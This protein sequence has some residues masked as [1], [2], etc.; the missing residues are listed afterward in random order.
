M[1]AANFDQAAVSKTM[2]YFLRHNPAAGGLALDQ[3][4]WTDFLELVGALNAKFGVAAEDVLEI[5][6]NDAKRRYVVSGGRIRAS[7]GHSVV[8]DL[9]LNAKSPPPR[10]YHGTVQR[11]LDSIFTSGLLKQARSHVHLSEDI[12]TAV[13][14]AIR[15]KHDIPAILEVDSDSMARQGHTFFLSENG[16][17]LVGSVPPEFLLLLEEEAWKGK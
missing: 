16:V 14:V 12:P 6:A 4:G 5:V 2:A 11:F 10:L 15:R 1:G 3:N 8:V 17:W 9:Q 13:V 7:Q